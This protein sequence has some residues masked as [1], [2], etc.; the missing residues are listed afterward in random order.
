MCRAGEPLLSPSILSV[1]PSLLPLSLSP[2]PLSIPAVSGPG[3]PTSASPLHSC[4]SVC[5]SVCVARSLCPIS[6]PRGRRRAVCVSVCLPDSAACSLSS[7]ALLPSRHNSNH[8]SR[9]V[10]PL[11]LFLLC[12][13]VWKPFLFLLLFSGKATP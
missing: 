12:A 6:G 4:L 10:A 1:S 9:P 5:L 13:S 8:C 7:P 2:L 3:R 11:A